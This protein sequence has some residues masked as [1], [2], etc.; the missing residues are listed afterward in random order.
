M[1]FLPNSRFMK[2]FAVIWPTKPAPC[3][4]PPMTA[5]RKKS[6]MNGTES[7]YCR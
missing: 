2:E 4:C 3:P 1:S 7:A 5:S 6:S